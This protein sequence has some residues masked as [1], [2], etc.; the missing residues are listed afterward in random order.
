MKSTRPENET[1]SQGTGGESGPLS[2]KQSKVLRDNLSAIS[3]LPAQGPVK[4]SIDV[5]DVDPAKK[6][7][8]R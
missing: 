2:A 8:P 1:Y 4:V 5:V 7:M 6:L 3:T